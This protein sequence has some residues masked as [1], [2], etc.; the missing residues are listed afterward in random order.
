MMMVTQRNEMV[1][2][3]YKELIEL[4]S[5]AIVS[6][7]AILASTYKKDKKNKEKIII[8]DHSIEDAEAWDSY[9]FEQLKFLNVILLS[10]EEA[11]KAW[12]YR[13]Y[14]FYQL[15]AAVKFMQSEEYEDYNDCMYEEDETESDEREAERDKFKLQQLEGALR[16]DLA[17]CT[18]VNEKY[19]SNYHM[20]YYRMKLVIELLIP[21]SK[22]SAC[23]KENL[24][25][26]EIQSTAGYI[27]RNKNDISA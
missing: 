23:F 18:K 14:L 25:L 27:G 8:E 13:L 1:L 6:T 22:K 3:I 10:H 19:K 21:L 17:F 7:N 11:S 12:H 24:I 16:E 15:S 9:I 26:K 5:I 20:W 4:E 2:S